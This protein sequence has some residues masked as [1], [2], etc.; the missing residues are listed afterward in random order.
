M[1]YTNTIFDMVLTMK[2]LYVA[3]LVLLACAPF[4]E[5][6]KAVMTIR[7]DN[8]IPYLVTTEVDTV[9]LQAYYVEDADF[10]I[11][12]ITSK[13][14][15][16]RPESYLKLVSGGQFVFIF[17]G[18]VP[19]DPTFGEVKKYTLVISTD[20]FELDDTHSL[21]IDTIKAFFS[22]SQV[23]TDISLELSSKIRGHIILHQQLVDT[24]T[25][26][27]V[28][29]G[30]T[31]RYSEKTTNFGWVSGRIDFRAMKKKIKEKSEIIIRLPA[32]I[33]LDF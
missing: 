17:K 14:D 25:G 27:L 6:S 20:K 32:G 24:L 7:H 8:Y 15:S 11:D 9:H 22:C 10:L 13:Y 18:H 16:L 19:E 29:E 23:A 26:N 3:S 33:Q 28:F 5:K 21:A 12:S 4:Y 2:C 1:A 31:I 30:K